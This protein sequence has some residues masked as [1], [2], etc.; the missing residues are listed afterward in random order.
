MGPITTSLV[1]FG[2]IF[3]GALFGMYL[4]RALPEKYLTAEIKD[5]IKETFVLIVTMSA[6]VLGLLV[7]SAKGHFDTEADGIVQLS[8][9][10]ISLDRTLAIYGPETKDARAQLREL[11]LSIIARMHP[12]KDTQALQSGAKARPGEALLGAIQE[13]APKDDAQRVLKSQALSISFNIASTRWLMYLQRATSTPSIL[14]F[15][16]IFWLAM[17]FVR[18]GIFYPTNAITVPSLFVAA[19]SVSAAVLLIMRLYS[20]YEGLLQ[21]PI[22]PLQMALQ[23]IGQ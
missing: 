1:A 13:L 21:I 7:A 9:N 15:V 8:A 4:R 10:L 23:Q 16:M 11:I 18:L 5:G 2:C 20:P 22:A 6:L 17:I 12:A 19:L 3:G 14:V